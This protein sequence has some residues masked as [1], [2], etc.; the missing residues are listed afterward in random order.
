MG[1]VVLVIMAVGA[2]LAQFVVVA[3]VVITVEVVGMEADS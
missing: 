3:I 1:V 2:S